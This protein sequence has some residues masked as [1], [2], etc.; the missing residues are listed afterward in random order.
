MPQTRGLSYRMLSQRTKRNSKTG[1]NFN[2][3]CTRCAP[4]PTRQ[5]MLCI[6]FQMNFMSH[7]FI[8]KPLLPPRSSPK[9]HSYALQW[10]AA[11]CLLT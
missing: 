3:T 11:P 9:K 8:C 4:F 5:I 6:W 7:C 2:I 10:S 1:C